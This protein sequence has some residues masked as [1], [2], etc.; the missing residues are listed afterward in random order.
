MMKLAQIVSPSPIRL[1]N[2]SLGDGGVNLSEC[3]TLGIGGDTVASTYDTPASLAQV[4]ISNIFIFA[5]IISFYF[6]QRAFS[7][8]QR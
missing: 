3:F 6:G 7:K 8:K 5:G 4:V 1:L 2:C